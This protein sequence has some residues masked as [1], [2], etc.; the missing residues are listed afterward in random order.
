MRG[1]ADSECADCSCGADGDTL[2]APQESCACLLQLHPANF[3]Y[4]RLPPLERE[5]E[6]DIGFH[7]SLEYHIEYME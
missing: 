7:Y 2:P 3:Q 5:E 6:L 4:H 1:M